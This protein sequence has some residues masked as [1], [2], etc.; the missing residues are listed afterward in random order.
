MAPPAFARHQPRVDQFL[1][2]EG[3]CGPRN[4]EGLPYIA[5]H[6][7]CWAGLDQQAEGSQPGR[8]PQGGESGDCIIYFHI[9]RIVE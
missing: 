8:V 7:A 3:E 2:V 1:E 4:P 5:G 6:A 9:S